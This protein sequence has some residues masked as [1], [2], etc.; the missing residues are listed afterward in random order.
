MKVYDCKVPG[1][2]TDGT[3]R[4]SQTTGLDRASNALVSITNGYGD[5][6]EL[7]STLQELSRVLDTYD[8]E[9]AATVQALADKYQSG[10]YQAEATAAGRGMIADALASESVL[11]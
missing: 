3:T 10:R 8:E 4:T 2:L 11:I 5:R 1:A 9:R 6:V 7:S